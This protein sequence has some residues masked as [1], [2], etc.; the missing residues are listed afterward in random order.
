VVVLK[1]AR[2]LIDAMHR[3]PVTL[4]ELARRGYGPY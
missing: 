4:Q 2:R 1:E 3:L